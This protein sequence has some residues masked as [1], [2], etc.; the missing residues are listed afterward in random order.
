MGNWRKLRNEEHQISGGAHTVE[1][2]D[3]YRVVSMGEPDL[4]VDGR[5]ILR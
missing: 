1:K 4:G 5:I 2:G 3:A